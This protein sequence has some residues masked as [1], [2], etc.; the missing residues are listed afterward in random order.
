MNDKQRID[1]TL[2]GTPRSVT[3][4]SRLLLVEL[5]R[6]PLQ[7]M[8]TRIGCL[9]GDCGACTVMMDGKVTKSCLI[10]A[11]A[12]DGA[13]LRTIEGL[14]EPEAVQQAFIRHN[15]FQCG[16]CTAGMIVVATDLLQR[17]A[18]PNRTE[19]REAI[20]GNLCRCTGYEN[21]VEAIHD[22][23]HGLHPSPSHS[24]AHT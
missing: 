19:I 14:V 13:D 15:A 21:I 12:A 8:G 6:E 4:D 24:P 9:T 17:N 10:L 1:L 7:A 18:K 23:A 20:S 11:V 22:A 2:N 5:I 3:F 16:Y